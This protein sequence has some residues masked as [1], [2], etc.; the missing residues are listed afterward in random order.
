MGW[1]STIDIS[2]EEAISL[3]QSRL[4]NDILNEMSNRELEDMVEDMGFGETPGLPHFGHNFIVV[5]EIK[6][7]V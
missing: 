7:E 2:R 3:I 5:N 4:T 1:K 6:E